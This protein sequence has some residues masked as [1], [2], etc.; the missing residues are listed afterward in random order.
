MVFHC[1]DGD[2]GTFSRLT[3]T[4]SYLLYH[5]RYLVEKVSQ[6]GTDHN[7]GIYVFI[8]S[9]V[10]SSFEAI[11]RSAR[12]C[13]TSNLHLYDNAIHVSSLVDEFSKPF[14]V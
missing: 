1:P 14:N 5:L 3:S 4:Y 9:A 13:P 12:D 10:L 8:P 7:K 2:L 6:S 11:Q